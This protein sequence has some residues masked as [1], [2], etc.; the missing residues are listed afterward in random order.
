MSVL[1]TDYSIENA[2][3][4]LSGVYKYNSCSPGP[5]GPKI[6]PFSLIISLE[7]EIISNVSHILT[8][9]KVIH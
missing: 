3:C 1:V 7:L 2:F 5:G 4:L 9:D 6:Y 8:N